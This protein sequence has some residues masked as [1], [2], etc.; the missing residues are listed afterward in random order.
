MPVACLQATT[1]TH[2]AL[3]QCTKSIF[4]DVIPSTV[5]PM[6]WPVPRTYMPRDR[7]WIWRCGVD[8]AVTAEAVLWVFTAESG[9]DH[10]YVHLTS[11]LLLQCFVVDQH[12]VARTLCA[13]LLV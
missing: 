8:T 4:G 2:E 12:Q 11:V 1:S 10:T 13:V 5:L 7:W 9:V 6:V 3:S